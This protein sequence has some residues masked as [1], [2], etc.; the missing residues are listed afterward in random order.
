MQVA[1]KLVRNRGT[2][3]I[4]KAGQKRGAALPGKCP[5]SS[6]LLRAG[7]HGGDKGTW[8]RPTD[9]LRSGAERHIGRHA[10]S[11]HVCKTLSDF[12]HPFRASTVPRR[13]R[14]WA[15]VVADGAGR[16]LAIVNQDPLARAHPLTNIGLWALGFNGLWAARSGCAP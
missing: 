4:I 13:M 5:H 10:H 14:P 15:T 2:N 1:R 12:S 11:T 8:T 3:T 6:R 9:A 7:Q 16:K